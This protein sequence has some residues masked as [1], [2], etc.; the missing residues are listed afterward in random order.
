MKK[1]GDLYLKIITI[2]LAVIV[3]AYVALSALLN[4]GSSY[5]LETAVLCEAGD[6]QTVSG[7]V[8]RSEQVI[9]AAQSVV[10]CE[11]NEGEWVGSGQTVATGYSTDAA[12]SQRQ[13]LASL[14]AELASLRYAAAGSEGADTTGLDQEIE[15]LLAEF[16]AMASRRRLDDAQTAASQLPQLILRRSVTEDD[17]LAINQRISDLDA[18]IATLEAQTESS[19]E[20]ITVDHSGYF[21]KTVDGLESRLT[22]EAVLTMTPSQFSQATEQAGNLPANA[23]GR[24]ATGQTWYFAAEI[25]AGRAGQIALGDLLTVS[26][27]GETLQDLQMEV[28]ALSEAEG[29]TC[30]LVLSCERNLQDVTALRRQDADIIFSSYS[31]LRVPKQAL[32]MVEGQTGV[33]VL[34]SARAQWKPVEILYEY[35]DGYVVALDKSSTNNLWPGDEIILTS[36]DI[37]DGKVMMDG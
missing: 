1:Q 14:Q 5:A 30:L 11:L 27:G 7:F 19:A 4:S 13:E 26:F 37:T 35:G 15:G 18:Q 25:P 22:P 29:E 36:E 20:P 9:T 10:V 31:G 28:E 17:T 34:E 6:G 3:L 32:Y 8:V 23:I 21:S 12:R 16:A 33:Y 24:L 2:V